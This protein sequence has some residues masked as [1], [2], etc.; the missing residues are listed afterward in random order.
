MHEKGFSLIELLTTLA[1]LT[2]LLQL[3]ST[4]FSELLRANRELDAAQML[5]S[6]MRNARAAAILYQHTALIHSLD[7]DW[8]RGWR[9][10][11]DISGKGPGDP[12]NP[13]LIERQSGGQVL[14][15]GNRPV[16]HFVRFSTLGN[17]LL[18]SGAFQ[19][20]TL[21]VCQTEQEYS[22]HQVVLSRSGRISLRSETAEQALCTGAG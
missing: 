16:Q 5:A 8:S 18:P 20:G 11:L 19:A 14:I 17:P 1:L 13:L 10:I 22:R 2:L 7:G 6:G 15:V 12:E 21:H 9:I 4:T 3:S